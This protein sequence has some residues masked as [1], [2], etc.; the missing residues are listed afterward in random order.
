MQTHILSDE[1]DFYS[2]CVLW[3]SKIY[4]VHMLI[5]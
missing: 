4:V 2:K 5:K 3:R 1:D